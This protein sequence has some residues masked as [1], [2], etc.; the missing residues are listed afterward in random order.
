MMSRIRSALPVLLLVS[1]VAS[2]GAADPL[3]PEAFA[4]RWVV[5]LGSFPDAAAARR[6]AAERKQQDAHVLTSSDFVGL[7]RG[8]HVLVTGPYADRKEAQAAADAMDKRVRGY[9]RYT[10]AL[11]SEVQGAAAS[12]APQ[13]SR[14]PAPTLQPASSKAANAAAPVSPPVESTKGAGAALAA[15]ASEFPDEGS[16]PASP[17]SRDS[18]PAPS[19][20]PVPSQAAVPAAP[21]DQGAAKSAP[22]G[23]SFAVPE[24]MNAEQA[25]ALERWRRA[26]ETLAG[27]GAHYHI[28]Q[29]YESF[30]GTAGGVLIRERITAPGRCVQGY[31]ELEFAEPQAG[32][33]VR[34]VTVLGQNCCAGTPCP[35]RSPGA[36]MLEL[37]E[38]RDPSWAID[39]AR[40]V[41]IDN[42]QGWTRRVL[43]E[44]AAELAPYS[45]FD[46]TEDTF[47]CP[48]DWDNRGGA[49]CFMYAAGKGYDFVWT[50]RGNSAVLER[51]VIAHRQ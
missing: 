51:I 25:A 34:T 18:E 19:A 5:V 50:R 10:G 35:E 39:P 33:E 8:Y 32:G 14:A 29:I 1:V 28:L 44:Q 22:S 23:P 7:T 38:T 15:K 16:A 43:R 11:R 31:R 40:G 30:A 46:P 2:P 17:R 48:S 49:H 45:H 3:P 9:A 6:E 12:D 42:L 20:A 21:V 26:G 13:P 4:K 41:E 24:F 47:E 37:F 36:V 27:A